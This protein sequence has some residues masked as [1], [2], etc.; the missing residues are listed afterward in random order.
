MLGRLIY[1]FFRLSL[2]LRAE[3]TRQAFGMDG[4][5][6]LLYNCPQPFVA[7]LL[8]RYGAFVDD[9]VTLNSLLI[10]HNAQDSY[11][12][13]SVGEGCH[14]GRLVFLDLTQPITIG[15]RATI[16]M[17]AVIL[18]HLDVG[19]S[20]LKNRGYPRQE[21]GVMID[22]GAYIG[23]CSIILHGVHIGE[24]ALVAAGSLV[25]NDVSPYEVVG[26]IPARFIKS[27]ADG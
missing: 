18:T 16:S 12:N 13:L 4:V 14:I 24:G 27:I 22:T 26:G 7:Q 19:R 8:R 23:A 3:F 20:P 17:G 25:R 6:N 9:Q 10:I 1:H 21:G 11:K 2:F 15:A 5:S